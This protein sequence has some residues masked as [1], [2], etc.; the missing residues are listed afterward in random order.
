MR[1]FFALMSA[2]LSVIDFQFDV[3]VV[4]E[5]WLTQDADCMFDLDG[6]KH[7]AIYR[8]QYGG[9]ISV[10]YKHGINVS[11]IKELTYV[12]DTVEV[13]SFRANIHSQKLVFICVYR[14]PM[15]SISDFNDMFRE[16]ILSN[17]SYDDKV[18]ICGDMNVNL[19][20]PLR[21]R[22]IDEFIHNFIGYGYY[23]IITK[24]T[25]IT[26]ENPITKF[27]L[28]DQIW[29]NF[30]VND[31]ISGVIDC[32]L[33]D[34]LPSYFIMVT[35]S[36]SL[37]DVRWSRPVKDES[38]VYR[39]VMQV[40]ITSFDEV[41]AI[42]NPCLALS[43]LLS[44]L[45]AIYYSIFPLKKFLPRKIRKPP[46]LTPELKAAVNK[47]YKLLKLLRR[48]S[49]S[50]N[51]FRSYRNMLNYT[52]KI[53]KQYYYKKTIL[54]HRHNSRKTWETLNVMLGR[55]V[56]GNLVSIRDNG[57]VLD[58]DEAVNRFNS[59]FTSIAAELAEE[60]PPL[61]TP[62]QMLTPPVNNSCF[63]TPTSFSEIKDIL[64]SFKN[65]TCHKDEIQPIILWK[66]H[67]I[68]LPILVHI[69]NNCMLHG[70]YPDVLKH[71]RVVPIFKSG[72]S[73]AV[74]NY[75]P[76][77]TLSIFNKIFEKILHHRFTD[78]FSKNNVLIKSQF[79]FRK[80]SSTSLAIFYLV[81]DLLKSFHEK[82]YTICLFLDLRKAFDTVDKTVL[83]E[84]LA[85][86]GIRGSVNRLLE[87]YLTDRDQYAVLNQSR[88][89]TLPVNIGVPQGSVLG[90]LLFNIYINDIAS[91][92]H[93][94]T[95]LFADDAVFYIERQKFDDAVESMR[96]FLISLSQWL[97]GSRL[98]A[99]E[100]KTKLMLFSAR[101]RPDLPV[102]TFNGKA[103]EWVR[104]I[105]YL[106]V[107]ID[108]SLKFSLHITSVCSGLSK[109][110][111][112]MYSVSKFVPRRT[113]VTLYYSLAYSKLIQSIIIWGGASNNVIRPLK[114]I[115]NKIMRVIL[116]VK[117]N[118]N[119]IPSVGTIDMYR[120][121][122]I[123]QYE[124]VYR[125][126]LLKFIRDAMYGNSDF[127]DNIYGNLVP[128]HSY[129]TRS[130]RLNVPQVRLDIEKQSTV[131]QS[132][133]VF[134]SA[135][136]SLLEPSSSHSFKN[137]YKKAVLDGYVI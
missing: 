131:Y 92:S 90:P 7:S 114:V 115:I 101:L 55:R 82:S 56:T 105:K 21:L 75:R 116:G 87:S 137:R 58:S 16:S 118:A 18:L 95:I 120:R 76:I 85:H 38:L 72:D 35:D 28:L 69:F 104:S 134:N 22:P 80:K 53:S 40:A 117:Y 106:G 128:N 47:K 113:L 9:G 51:S 66:I 83:L 102:V 133:A 100:N 111:G 112:I 31:L 81:Q 19:F 96:N 136:E 64:Y 130:T 126:F 43:K 93:V 61:D 34:H 11:I 74:S 123:L 5:T 6:Y 129:G 29:C 24:P 13:L 63:L 25:R 1:N 37:E 45:Y 65:K 46:W 86:Y 99:H 14:P 71:A 17:F 30:S 68:V 10:Y 12:R 70:I 119:N 125:Y 59:Y 79:G 57:R 54:E 73:T 108:D 110:L 127:F 36:V 122:E 50:R 8:N 20:N 15:N 27:S 97:A 103:L 32:E 88:S 44:I 4:T 52:I 89:Q 60:L 132:V 62:R 94:E 124:D 23:P 33:S 107:I 39:F 91:I 48:G 42:E 98:T 77:S 41:L 121:L 78:F 2:F 3:I 109:V 84:K 67:E 26:E 49:I 135:P